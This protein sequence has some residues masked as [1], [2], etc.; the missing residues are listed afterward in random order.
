MYRVKS[1]AT[2]ESNFFINPLLPLLCVSQYHKKKKKLPYDQLTE[3]GKESCESCRSDK[4][5]FTNPTRFP[6]Y[7]GNARSVRHNPRSLVYISPLTDVAL[8][9]NNSATTDTRDF[10]DARLAST[11][12]NLDS[13]KKRKIPNLRHPESALEVLHRLGSKTRGLG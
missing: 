1:N 3:T 10:G 12:I 6:K 7:L 13:K 4:P 5:Y 8:V 9:F 11:S 2:Y